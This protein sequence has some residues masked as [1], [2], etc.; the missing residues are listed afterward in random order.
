MS[1][2]VARR[3]TYG[4]SLLLG[5]AVWE[6]AAARTPRVILVPF[7]ETLVDLGDLAASGT[8]ARA[9]SSTLLVFAA[10]LVVAVVTGYAAGLVLARNRLIR[11]GF[12]DYVTVLYATPMVAIIPFVLSIFG[13]GVWPKVL[14]VY[15]FAVFPVII[16]TSEGAR[17]I[18]PELV[19][20]A[21]SFGS[22]E[23][24]LWRDVVIPYTL[25][26]AM[27]GVRQAIARGFVGAIAAEFFLSSSGLGQQL[28]INARLFDTG[29]VLALTLVVTLL[30]VVLMGFGRAL[31][32]H[33]APW[34]GGRR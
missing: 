28:I 20:V 27:T 26:H 19:E 9:L 13:F 6:L 4:V 16:N 33:V 25:P 29:K 30:G 18:R 14:V 5:I 8:L 3:L 21:R 34:Y 7:T 15:L 1:E 12:D 32:R 11:V 31:E 22:T 24:Q 23:A 2:T 10:G 17:S